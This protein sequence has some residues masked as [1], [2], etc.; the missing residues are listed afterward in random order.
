MLQRQAE[1]VT[2][3]HVGRI[4]NKQNSRV[5]D[6]RTSQAHT[7]AAFLY[8]LGELTASFVSGMHFD[9]PGIQLLSQNT[10]MRPYNQ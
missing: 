9:I 4:H 6:V 7:R 5:N 3:V 8:G 1:K 10:N 2:R